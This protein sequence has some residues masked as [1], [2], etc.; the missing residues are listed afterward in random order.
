M[1]RILATTILG[2]MTIIALFTATAASAA[3]CLDV[4]QNSLFGRFQRV[5]CGAGYI[6]PGNATPVDQATIIGIIGG[7]LNIVYGLTG[8][9][10]VGIIIYGGFFW[11]SA[12]GNSTQVEEAEVLIRN[13]VIGIVITFSA[14]AIS[15]FVLT[16]L[17]G[18]R[19]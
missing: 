9:V 8:V 3:P 13:S 5:A 1:K 19:L 15:T 7:I 6:G 11:L 14:F 10:F 17:A 18:I 12:R 2:A 4:E 16:S